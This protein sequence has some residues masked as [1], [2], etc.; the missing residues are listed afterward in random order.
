M[1]ASAGAIPSSVIDNVALIINDLL[2][3]SKENIVEAYKV[4]DNADLPNYVD[5]FAA[6]RAAELPVNTSRSYGLFVVLQDL[7]NMDNAECVM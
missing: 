2:E 3:T 7:E 4:T 5:D 1:D 6:A